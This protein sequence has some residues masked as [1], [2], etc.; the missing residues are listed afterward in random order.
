MPDYPT[1]EE[2]GIHSFDELSHFKVRKE[3]H[4][5][6]LKIYYRRGKGSLLPRSKK[7]T[8]V[9]PR[10]AIPLQYRDNQAWEQ[11]KQSSP[12]LQKAVDELTQL[13][14]PVPA[15]PKDQ[16]TLFLNDLDH[17][18]KVMLAKIAEMRRQ[19]EELD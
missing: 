2:M 14:Q 5:D 8:F 1:L 18:E 11:F 12:R 3:Q 7:F 10:T 13:T 19:V 4:A 6:V 17:L 15:S 16:K 9:R